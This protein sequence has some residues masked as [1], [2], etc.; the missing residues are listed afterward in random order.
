VLYCRAGDQSKALSDKL[1]AD[2]I[3]VPFLEGGMLAWESEFL[4]IER[5]DDD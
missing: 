5:G 4:P 3:P 2:G 1:G